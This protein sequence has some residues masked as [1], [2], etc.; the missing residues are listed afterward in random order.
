ML[1]FAGAL[2]LIA[3]SAGCSVESLAQVALNTAVQVATQQATQAAIQT[4]IE[5]AKKQGSPAPGTTPVPPTT[6]TGLPIPLPSIPG[7]PSVFGDQAP[8]GDFAAEVAAAHAQAN[9]ERAAQG[10][11]AL[12]L[13]AS[14]SEVARKYSVYMATNG[15]F[16]HEDLDGKGPSDRLTAA[17]IGWSASGENILYNYEG[18]G[19]AAITQWMNSPGHRDNILRPSFAKVGYGVYK[20]PSG[21]YWWT[22]D[23]TN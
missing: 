10:L 21:K 19:L 16:A 7:L 17:G 8:T 23:F 15:H 13:V 14:I 5:A 9:K 2:V 12:T 22:Q 18:T 11:P 1:K 3:V 20:D 6:T 4:A